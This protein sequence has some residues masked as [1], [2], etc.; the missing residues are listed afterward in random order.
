MAISYYKGK[1]TGGNLKLRATPNGTQVAIIPT[2]TVLVVQSTGSGW[3]H[4]FYGMK[5]GYVMESY[6]SNQGDAEYWQ[7]LFGLKNLYQGCSNSLYV[8]H[9]QNSLIN[10]G[11]LNSNGNDGVFGPATKA[12]VMQFQSNCNLTADGIVGN[13]TKA[14][15]DPSSP[16]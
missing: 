13:A 12:A 4:T 2:N 10:L 16:W 7:Y 5:E 6:L 3:A 1:V 11:L 8:M 14:A 9:V 15:L